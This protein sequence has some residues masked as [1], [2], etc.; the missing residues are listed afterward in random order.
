MSFFEVKIG[1]QGSDLCR[2]PSHTFPS[3]LQPSTCHFPLAKHFFQH[4]KSVLFWMHVS[5]TKK[6]GTWLTTMLTG[7]EVPSVQSNHCRIYQELSC[8]DLQLLRSCDPFRFQHNCGA[9]DVFFLQ[10]LNETK[11][12]CYNKF[13]DLLTFRSFAN[14]IKSLDRQPDIS[15]AVGGVGVDKHPVF[16]GDQISLCRKRDVFLHFKSR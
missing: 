15:S 12:M 16:L 13:N 2:W 10:S 9:V 4:K 5:V 1:S 7:C 11:K 14:P 8:E 6:P 3:G